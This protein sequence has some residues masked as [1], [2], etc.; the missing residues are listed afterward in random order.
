MSFTL[1]NEIIEELEHNGFEAYIVGGVVRDR[2]LER[3]TGDIDIATSAMPDEVQRIFS[4]TIPVGIEHGTV[5]VR[6]GN[7]SFE[8]TTFRTEGRYEDFRRPTEVHFHH[9][10]EADLS[11]RDYT[12]NALALDRYGSIIDPYGGQDDIKHNLLK[13]V[14][15]PAERFKEDP[16]RMMRGIRFVSILGFEFEEETYSALVE[17]AYL[18]K[19]ISV[20]RIRDEFE[21]MLCGEHCEHALDLLEKSKVNQHLPG[22]PF[23]L[24]I[25]LGKYRWGSLKSI[26]ERWAAFLIRNSVEDANEWLRVWK[27]PNQVKA[28]TVLIVSLIQGLVD[29]ASMLTI[30][31][32]GLD[33]LKSVLRVKRFLGDELELEEEDLETLHTQL[34]IKNRSEL[35]MDGNDLQRFLKRNPGPWIAEYIEQIE[36]GVIEGKIEN[37]PSGVKEWIEEWQ[38][39]QGKD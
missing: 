32:Y 22:G 25:Y 5:I 6:H 21:K 16:L 27:L 35:A 38:Q 26:E 12:I 11:R 28:K 2:L 36:R 4:K 8:V 19:K 13:A 17:N 37:T 20:E 31:K 23:D 29:C 30:Y 34:P 15:L 1:A 10:I 33:V 24:Q 7:Q 18:L 39:P 9:S 14:G 3:Q